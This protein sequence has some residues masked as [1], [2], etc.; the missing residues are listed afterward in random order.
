M[1]LSLPVRARPEVPDEVPEPSEHYSAE[2]PQPSPG[3]RMETAAPV[4]LR[5]L[6]AVAKNLPE[7]DPVRRLIEGEPDF[8]PLSVLAAK[9]DSWV[10][11][12]LRAG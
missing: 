9:A 4:D 6:K 10:L 5:R 8:L 1:S 11:L 12:L 7:S 2:G 3:D